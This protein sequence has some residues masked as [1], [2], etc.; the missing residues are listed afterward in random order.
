MGRV[1]HIVRKEFHQLKRDK[2]MRGMVILAPIFQILILGYAAD[3]DVRDVPTVVCDQ[4]R[5][6]E[7]RALAQAFASSGSFRL[8]AYVE[9]AAEAESRLE[10]GGAEIG[11][12]LPPNFGADLL[13]GGTPSIQLLVDGSRSNTAAVAL[14]YA[15]SI[16]E[17]FSRDYFPG[18]ARLRQPVEAR[19]RVWYNPELKSR[20]FMIPG[21]FALLV[22]V[23][24]IILTSLA[25]V[26]E[27]EIGTLEQLVVSPLRKAELIMGKL[28]PFA[29]I[30]L[31]LVTF[32]LGACALFFGIIPRG[33]IAILYLLT[34]ILILSTLGIGLL[35]STLART[36]QQA[37]MYAIFF[38]MLPMMMLSGFAFPIANMPAPIRALTYLMPLRYYMVIVRSIFLKGSGLDILWPQALPMLA[39]GAVFIGFSVAR[40]KKQLE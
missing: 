6:A 37:M 30:G 33:S 12:I 10:K 36:Q 40:F 11:L 19:T 24:T 13:K 18:A 25:I 20:P 32:T 5:S 7:S 27:K 9:N 31:V 35:V 1:A 38:F 8:T 23:F 15:Q 4:D 14:A 2:K 28:I 29:L 26:K 34:L 22:M 39:L 16:T 21:V 17:D 3:M